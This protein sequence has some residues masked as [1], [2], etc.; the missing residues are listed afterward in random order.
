MEIFNISIYDIEKLLT[1]KSTTN[2]AKK[3]PT[4][5]HNFHNIFSQADLDILSPYRLYDYKILFMEEKTPLWGY[6]YNM[7]QDELKVLKKYLE[8]NLSKGFIK[9]SFSSNMSSLLFAGK[10]GGGL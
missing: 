3:L 2:L 9:A 4:E 8:E 5:Y 6:L 10:P 1:P 7:S